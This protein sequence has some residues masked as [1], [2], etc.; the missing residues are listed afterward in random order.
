MNPTRNELAEAI[1][2]SKL[3]ELASEGVDV[4]NMDEAAIDLL[5][6]PRLAADEYRIVGESGIEHMVRIEIGRRIVDC[7]EEHLGNIHRP[8]IAP[9]VTAFLESFDGPK[10]A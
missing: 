4:K 1:V 3:A 7:L 8:D 6:V 2:Q 5:L 10:A 9:C